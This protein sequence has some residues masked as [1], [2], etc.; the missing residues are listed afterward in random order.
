[1]S[2]HTLMLHKVKRVSV[3]RNTLFSSS[4]GTPFVVQHVRIETEDGGNFE[5][6]LF[7]SDDCDGL[8]DFDTALQEV[9]Q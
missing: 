8:P 2:H 1:M 7:L 4:S 9:A 5:I 3:D 6:T